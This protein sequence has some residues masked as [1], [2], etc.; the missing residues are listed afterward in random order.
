M[1]RGFVALAAAFGALGVA[2]GA[3]GAHALRARVPAE[4]LAIHLTAVQYQLVHALALGL[5]GLMLLTGLGGRLAGAAG[6]AFIAGIVI[7]PGSLFLI[8]LTGQRGW[9]AVAPF[10]G[11]AFILGWLLLGLAAWRGR[12]E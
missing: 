2:A 3:F 5:T 11:T 7:F 9:G 4:V 8:V 1:G 10:G 6:L 12:A